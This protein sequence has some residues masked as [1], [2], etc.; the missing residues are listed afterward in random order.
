MHFIHRKKKSLLCGKLLAVEEDI[1]YSIAKY[2]Q[3]IVYTSE[4]VIGKPFFTVHLTLFFTFKS[5]STMFRAQKN[6]SANGCSQIITFTSYFQTSLK[7]GV[8]KIQKKVQYIYFEICILTNFLLHGKFKLQAQTLIIFWPF[9]WQTAFRLEKHMR[10]WTLYR[11]DFPYPEKLGNT[12]TTN[13]ALR[14]DSKNVNV[15]VRD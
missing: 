1:L 9:F 15:K 14:D 12:T 3:G 10:V 7:G 2:K 4:V 8:F 13:N 6:R 11:F 5:K